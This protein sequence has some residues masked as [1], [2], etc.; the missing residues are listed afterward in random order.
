MY[1]LPKGADFT[2][3]ESLTLL[4]ICFGEHDLI[5]N[6]DDASITIMSAIRIKNSDALGIQKYIDYRSAAPQILN[7]IGKSLMEVTTEE[8]GTLVLTFADA[9]R[10]CIDDDS[11]DFESFIIEHRDRTW[12]V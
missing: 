4:Q 2:F 11:S 3:L 10:L 7:L 6:F 9:C 5:L 12:V 8:P 1:G